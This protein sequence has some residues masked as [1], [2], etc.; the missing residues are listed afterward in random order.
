MHLSDRAKGTKPSKGQLTI[1]CCASMN[2]EKQ[3]LMVIGMSQNPRCLKGIKSLPVNYK[4]NKNA[5]TTVT[6]FKDWLVNWNT[7]PNR[8]ICIAQ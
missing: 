8:N 3:K 2:V 5:W 7:E 4:A 6:I 1:L